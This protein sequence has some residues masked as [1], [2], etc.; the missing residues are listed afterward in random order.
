[1]VGPNTNNTDQLAGEA[2]AVP[3]DGLEFHS[4]TETVPLANIPVPLP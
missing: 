1:M 2:L 3:E 4:V